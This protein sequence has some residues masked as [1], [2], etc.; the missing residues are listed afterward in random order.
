VGLRIALALV[1]AL[2]TVS[3]F[4]SASSENETN[5]A[6]SKPFT[7]GI[8]SDKP[9]KKIQAAMPFANHMA[10]QL[11]H[12]GYTHG[13]VVV[14]SNAADMIAKIERGDVQLISAT[15]YSAL[16]FEEESSVELS[17]LRWKQNSPNYTS[18]IFT[19]NDVGIDSLE[20]L[21]G[22][23]IAFEKPSSTSA[24]FLPASHILS[25]G[26]SLQKLDSTHQKPDADKIGYLFIKEQLNNANELNMSIWVYHNRVDAAAFSHLDW[27]DASTA[28]KKVSESL[29]IISET[30][31]YP[32]SLML[33]STKLGGL[34]RLAIQQAMYLAHQHESGQAA[35]LSFKETTKIE[36]ISHTSSQFIEQS[37]QTFSEVLA[38]IE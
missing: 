30:N 12:F 36:P 21:K 5:Q 2:L 13:D 26:I 37:R 17:G 4:A 3:S 35:L 29:Q 28:P 33:T 20:Q 32:R 22:K 9:K 19:K 16:Y 1:V 6:M 38:L 14:T 27:G 11:T 18:V 34:E 24:F 31:R 25:A 8:V 7:I 10:S 23:T 15:L